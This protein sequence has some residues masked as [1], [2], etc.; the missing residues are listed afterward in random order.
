MSGGD[1]KEMFKG[2]QKNDLEL[3][4][5]YL[6]IGVDPNYQ[7]PEYMSLPLAE[8]I[9]YNNTDIT[10]LLLS[11]GASPLIIEMESGITTMEIAK[12]MNNKK[13]IDLFEKFTK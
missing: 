8:S 4:R 2:V 12:K 5:Y 3:V 10:E 6:R 13:A 7:H 1:W 9:R 11:N